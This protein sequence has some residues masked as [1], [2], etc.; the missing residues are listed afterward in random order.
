[1]A[2]ITM[3]TMRYL[4]LL[5]KVTHIK[6]SKCFTYGG[7]LYFAIPSFLMGKALG[8]GALSLKRL[9]EQIGKR[10]KL[11]AEPT[12][13]EEVARFVRD[14]VAP[15]SFKEARIEQR[16]VVIVSGGMQQKAQ[17]LGRNKQHYEELAL[18]VKDTF[19]LELKI[20]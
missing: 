11:V 3:Q 17:L 15:T 6:T 18:I 20:M 5:D 9:Q 14:I 16:T 7:T 13:Q 1:M 19:G 8:E 2:T 12:G 10:V 4:N